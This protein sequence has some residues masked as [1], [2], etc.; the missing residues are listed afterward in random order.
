[1]TS[2]AN[3]LDTMDTG[4]CCLIR[5]ILSGRHDLFA[6][7]IAPHLAP[8]VR[9]VRA[10][11]GNHPDVEDIVQTTALKALKHLGQFRRESSFRTWLIQI[12]VN[13][14]RQW[15][16]KSG[17][18]RLLVLEPFLLAQ[19]PFADERRS[20]LVECQRAEAIARLRS[21]LARLPEKDRIV[22]LLRDLEELSLADAAVR[23]GLTLPAT[24]SRHFRARRKMAKLITGLNHSQPRSRS[25][26]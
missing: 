7:L 25:C 18:S 2:A 6:E 1:M 23:L 15:R 26:R 4:E 8:L 17:S 13:E 21:A 12:G 11:V 9:I 5:E 3:R 19:L 24:K 10:S 20:S 14:A 16:R 22:I